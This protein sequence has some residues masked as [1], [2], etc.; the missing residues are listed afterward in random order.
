ML[1]LGTALPQLLVAV[2]CGGKT[3]CLDRLVLDK[4]SAGGPLGLVIL[5][6]CFATTRFLERLVAGGSLR[7]MVDVVLV[8]DRTTEGLSAF[9]NGQGQARTQDTNWQE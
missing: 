2:R 8:C 5:V 9:C 3:L 1:V 4:L 7:A 6:G